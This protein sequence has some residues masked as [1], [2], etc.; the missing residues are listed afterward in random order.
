MKILI[1]DIETSAN[2]GWVWGKYEQNVIEFKQ[3]WFILSFAYKWYGER[4]THVRALP[5]YKTYKR[6]KTND[7]ELVKELWEL[8]D[9]ADIVLGHNSDRFDI[10][11]A[12]ARFV[13]HGFTPP[14]PYKTIDT[15]KAARKYFNFNSNK[16]DDLAKKFG[17]GA[18]VHHAG[19]KLWEGCMNGDEKSWNTMKRYN[20]GDVTLTEKIYKQL[21]PWMHNH[22]NINIVDDKA[23]ACPACGSTKMQKRG[24]GYTQLGKYQRYQ[25]QC[26]KWSRGKNIRTAQ[27]IR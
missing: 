20:K 4:K 17:I 10:R 2:L 27:E 9:E 6:S 11:K 16:L 18:K 26:G 21:R 23:G 12:N 22:P 8:F 24:Y 25:C 3:E 13:E 15:L 14:A 1:F 19:W 7:K 5:D